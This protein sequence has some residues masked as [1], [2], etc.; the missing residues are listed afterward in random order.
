MDQGECIRPC[1]TDF[2]NFVPWACNQMSVESEVVVT[3]A[4]MSKYVSVRTKRKGKRPKPPPPEDISSDISDD[5]SEQFNLATAF[6]VV[7]FHT[8]GDI[9]HIQT[10]YDENMHLVRI[11]FT[12]N[13]TIPRQVL[14]IIALI[15]PLHK[16]LTSIAVDSG[17]CMGTIYEI[18]KILPGST[19]TELCLD[20]TNVPQANYHILLNQNTLKHLS[21]AKCNLNDDVVKTIA[22]K[23][24]EPSPAAKS[25][26]VLN[27]STNFITDLGAK[28]LAEA[29]RSNRRLSY[30][31]ISDN[32]ITDKGAGYIFDTLV[33]FP[34][35]NQEY[36]DKKARYSVY[37]KEK[38]DLIFRTIKDIKIMDFEK[39]V[40]KRKGIKSTSATKRKRAKLIS[41]ADTVV[42]SRLHMDVALRDKAGALVEEMMGTFSDT[43][44]RSNTVTRDGIIYCL[45]NNT[46]CYLNIAYNNL[47]FFSL[48]K[49]CSILET[50]KLWRRQP[51]GLINVRIDGNYLP[52]H[53]SQLGD[54]DDILESHLSCIKKLSDHKTRTSRSARRSIVK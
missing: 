29:L 51:R 5:S 31:N 34:L 7:A 52:A 13:K 50:Q 17:L 24:V 18:S 35:T 44:D 6:G 33:E 10:F 25:L 39:K 26:T 42:R 46:L 41:N 15:I 19:I 45:G 9:I 48:E 11:K 20:Y 28:H 27:L 3:R 40:A 49:L 47:T 30:L 36:M 37:L 12:K 14:K 8:E 2:E 32:M 53:C 21:L 1:P 16:H 4:V 38:W 43:F 23:I 54:I 22:K